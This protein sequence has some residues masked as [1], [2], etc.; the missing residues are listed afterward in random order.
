MQAVFCCIME[1]YCISVSVYCEL[2]WHLLFLPLT[3]R[4][5]SSIF[6]TGEVRA[7]L[8]VWSFRVRDRIGICSQIS[9]YSKM[10]LWFVHYPHWLTVYWVGIRRGLMA[11]AFACWVEGPGF[12]S[13]QGKVTFW[14]TSF[15]K[16]NAS[17]PLLAWWK[18]GWWECSLTH[19]R[20]GCV[21]S[22]LCNW[23]T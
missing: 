4:L 6:L 8:P 16:K 14:L 11:K 15:G 5:S 22:C 17:H 20:L 9:I 3:A 18:S 12:K 13:D 1:K 19:K 2:E 21:L 23:C 10:S 7:G